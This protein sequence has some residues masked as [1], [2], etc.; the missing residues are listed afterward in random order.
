MEFAIRILPDSVIDGALKTDDVLTRAIT[1][2]DV[3]ELLGNLD[4]QSDL[5]RQVEVAITAAVRASLLD[6]LLG[7]L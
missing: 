1:D 4:D 5:G 3:R 2:L 7:L 6:R